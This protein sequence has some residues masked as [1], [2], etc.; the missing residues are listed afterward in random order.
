ME[1]KVDAGCALAAFNEFCTGFPA[2]EV[3]A[4]L[5]AVATVS[6]DDAT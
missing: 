5:T 3:G 2:V 4:G 1:L 6:A